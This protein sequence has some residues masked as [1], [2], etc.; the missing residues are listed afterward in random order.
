MTTAVIYSNGS[1][2]CERVAQL[3]KAISTEFHQYD[4]GNHFTKQQ[5]QMEFGGDAQYPQVAYG[6]RHLGNMKETL[7]FLKTNGLL[8]K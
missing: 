4:L 2:E 1:Q 3:L 6:H 5:F 8:D 7:Q